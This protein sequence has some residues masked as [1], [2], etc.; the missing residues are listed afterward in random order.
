M[1]KELTE[2]WIPEK[3][4]FREKQIKEINELFEGF[5]KGWDDGILEG[6]KN[7]DD[8]YDESVKEK[9]RLEQQLSNKEKEFF[10]KLEETKKEIFW[11]TRAI[12]QEIGV[13]GMTNQFTTIVGNEFEALKQKLEKK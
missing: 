2:I 8:F 5:K 3:I 11:K 9:E 6:G 1:V 4:L 10:E 12:P 7:F 13:K